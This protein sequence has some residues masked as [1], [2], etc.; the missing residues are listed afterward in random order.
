MRRYIPAIVILSLFLENAG[1]RSAWA[2]NPGEA[3]KIGGVAGAALGGYTA[4][5]CYDKGNCTG[6]EALGVW[7]IYTGVGIGTALVLERT[8]R[9][10]K[11]TPPPLTHGFGHIRTLVK[12]GNRIA[13]RDSSGNRS[14]GTVEAISDSAVLLRTGSANRNFFESDIAEIT[15]RRHS[16]DGRAIMSG[17]LVGLIGGAIA[18]P[19][20]NSG[21]WCQGKG[22]GTCVIGTTIL[23]GALFGGLS[24]LPKREERIFFQ[25]LQPQRTGIDWNVVPMIS[26]DTRGAAM[27]IKF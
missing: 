2:Q 27:T 15:Q 13:I 22:A 24:A 5:V 10:G 25:Q 6:N 12:P 11:T 20:T 21:Q 18:I 14:E 16:T 8:L 9:N 19:N 17:M 26:K 3:A 7:G 1:A 23:G 4:L